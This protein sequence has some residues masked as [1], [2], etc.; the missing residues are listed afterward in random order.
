[1]ARLPDLYWYKDS[2]RTNFLYLYSFHISYI[3][4]QH[5]LMHLDVLTRNLP[6]FECFL[7]LPDICNSHNAN[8]HF[9][10]LMRNHNPD[11]SARLSH[12]V[13]SLAYN[14]YSAVHSSMFYASSPS[15]SKTVFLHFR[16]IY[17]LP[18]LFLKMVLKPLS[19][20]GYS[21]EIYSFRNTLLK[22]LL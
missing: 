21:F 8:A 15:P 11:F 19:I 9:L 22:Y 5:L 10:F 20:L 1:M 14:I 3:I 13:L 16:V 4:L 17:L 7:F 6:L 18:E 2:Q 12:T